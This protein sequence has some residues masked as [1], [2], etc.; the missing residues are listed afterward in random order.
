MART[1]RHVACSRFRFA[2]SYSYRSH[3]PAN[4]C[5]RVGST[6]KGPTK[7]R[8]RRPLDKGGMFGKGYRDAVLRCDE[9]LKWLSLDFWVV[10]F[11]KIQSHH[12]ENRFVAIDPID[13]MVLSA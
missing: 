6:D 5:R 7:T 10:L 3:R 12:I 11:G 2:S 13:A 9:F 8:G 1:V 4:R